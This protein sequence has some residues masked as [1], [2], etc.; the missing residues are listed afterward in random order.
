[1]V[2]NLTCPYKTSPRHFESILDGAAARCSQAGEAADVFPTSVSGTYALQVIEIQV[3]RGPYQAQQSTD[4]AG[5]R[6]AWLV[7]MPCLV[8][9]R[10]GR[11]LRGRTDR[12]VWARPF[13]NQSLQQTV[14]R[15]IVIAHQ[16]IMLQ[17]RMTSHPPFQVGTVH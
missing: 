2:E 4:T 13:R 15:S 7:T 5:T 11:V 6:L 12:G 8:L 16:Q 9:C 17:R 14:T 3:R 1:M 10:A